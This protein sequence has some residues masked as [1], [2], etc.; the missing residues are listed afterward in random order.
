MCQFYQPRSYDAFRNIQLHIILIVI[1][2]L[3]YIYFM[4]YR[5]ESRIEVAL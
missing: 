2:G 1:G 5:N 4:Y 3:N